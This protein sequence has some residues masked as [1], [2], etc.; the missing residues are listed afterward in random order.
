[1]QLRTA[2][3]VAALAALAGSAD[4]ALFSFAS[5][6]ADHAWTFT[7]SG[8]TFSQ[9][10]GV[11]DPIVLVIDDMNGPLPRLEF[12]CR[13]TASTTLTFAGNVNVG[14]AV[15]HNYAASGSFS[16]VDVSTNVTILSGA[17]SGQLFTAR[18][19]ALSW[20]TTA[21]LQGDSTVGTMN[22]TWGGAN[23]P[24]YNLAT[25]TV[26]PGQFGFSLD[27]INTNGIIPWGGQGA[28]VNLGANNFPNATWFSEG[29]FVATNN[30]P[31][32]A[33]ATLLGLAG[34]LGARRRRR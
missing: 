32:P 14:G 23:L 15:S 3:C 24:G 9:A 1:M 13:F 6:T 12:S 22:L 19:A 5:D 28:G 17:Y 7:G 30:I 27:A 20:F 34:V 25:N 8:A 21:A 10:T 11:N 33:G 4:A 31:A 29:S 26:Y 18:G 16:F 2:V